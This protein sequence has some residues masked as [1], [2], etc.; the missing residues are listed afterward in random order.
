MVRCAL[1]PWYAVFESIRIRI[2]PSLTSYQ[3]ILSAPEGHH[4]KKGALLVGNPCLKELKK[5]LDDLPCAQEE[6]EMIASILKTTPLTGIHA[7]KAE[8]M[9]RMSSVGLIH[10]A[11]HGN[12]RT[13]EIAL[14]PNPGWSFKVPSKKGLHFKNVRCA[15]C[16]SSSSSCGAKLLSQWTRQS[17]RKERV[18]SVSHVP[19]WQLVLVLCW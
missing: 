3:L 2:V 7:T 18:W 9:K 16:Q 1:L 5:P 11:A 10:I 13:G 19:F 17:H 4:K 15:G 14:S 6:V 8:V 12:A